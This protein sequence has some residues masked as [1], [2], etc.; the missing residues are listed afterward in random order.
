MASEEKLLVVVAHPDDETFGTG[1]LIAH[2]TAR[3]V[4]TVVACATRGEAGT[5]APG[6]E[7][8]GGDLG[9]AREAEL[10]AAAALLGATRVEVFDW[11]DSGM[12]GAPGPGTLVAAPIEDVTATVAT[13]IDDVRPDVV[14]TLD[15]SD[16]HRDHAKIRD[17]T[18]AA[19]ERSSWAVP[20]VYLQC[21]PQTLMR[22][23]VAE[24][25]AKQP[26]SDHLALGE[27]GTPEEEITTYVDSA[28][29]L[30]IRERAMR[31]HAS[32]VSPYEVMPDALRLEFLTVERLCRVRPAWTGGPPE[33]ELFAT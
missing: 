8:A 2:A 11:L 15:A 1:S 12:E 4:E 27:L 7:P 5:P 13:L 6:H 20:R 33:T 29:V 23:W 19:V 14:V 24:L 21:L 9:A 17:A 32:Q 31:L 30:E 25:S 28:G 26:D 10:R 3:G 16:G 18:L 22:R